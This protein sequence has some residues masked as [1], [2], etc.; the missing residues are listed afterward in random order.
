MEIVVGGEKLLF[1]PESHSP[2]ALLDVLTV[3]NQNTAVSCC[4]GDI[5]E[6][7]GEFS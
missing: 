7:S 6:V 5:V 1:F 4:G 2:A 3:L